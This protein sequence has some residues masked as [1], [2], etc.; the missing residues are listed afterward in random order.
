M[1]LAADP[2]LLPVA[3]PGP[4]LSFLSS[5]E[6]GGLWQG[7]EGGY[8]D[9]SVDNIYGK[10]QADREKA[11]HLGISPLAYWIFLTTYNFPVWLGITICFKKL[12]ASNTMSINS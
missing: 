3:D 4:Q 10:N 9:S 2:F 8:L 7:Q 1:I 5:S 6:E 12:E 11:K